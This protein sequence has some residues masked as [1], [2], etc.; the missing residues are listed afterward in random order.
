MASR[1]LASAITFSP[2]TNTNSASLST[3]F[4]I[5]HGQATRS[6]LTFS[7]VIHFMLRSPVWLLL[8]R[9]SGVRKHENSTMR[10]RNHVELVR[11]DQH[12]GMR[13]GAGHGL[14]AAADARIDGL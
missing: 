6:T 2:G 13:A 3:N 4:L 1:R 9:T 10:G 12:R 14:H 11:W 8:R 7:R 5:S